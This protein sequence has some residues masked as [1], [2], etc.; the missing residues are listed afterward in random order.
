MREL[1]KTWRREGC[2][3]RLWDINRTDSLGKHRLAYQFKSGRRVIFE[4]DDFACSPMHAIDS[5]DTV[6]GL[7]GFLTCKPGDTDR[8][9]FENYTP[10]QLDWCQSGQSERIAM[11]IYDREVAQEA[12][13]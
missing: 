6:A 1:I 8:E 7:L 9:Y 5:L 12:R 2:T 10:E 3:L 13:R 11:W 4:G